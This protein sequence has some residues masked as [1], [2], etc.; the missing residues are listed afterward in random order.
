VILDIPG[1]TITVVFDIGDVCGAI[2]RTPLAIFTH[3]GVSE[4]KPGDPARRHVTMR[5]A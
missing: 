4:A 5:V 1:R 3:D 2:K